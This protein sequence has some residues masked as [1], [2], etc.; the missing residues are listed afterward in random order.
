M[1]L[2][3]KYFFKTLDPD[4][5]P[6]AGYRR[7]L[8]PDPKT[9]TRNLVVGIGVQSELEHDD[10]VVDDGA[11][12]G[13]QAGPAHLKVAQPGQRALLLV[14]F[15]QHVQTRTNVV[16]A[17]RVGFPRQREK[18]I[19]IQQNFHSLRSGILGQL[20]LEILERIYCKHFF[21]C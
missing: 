6:E 13:E 17:L 8:H 4:S 7:L 16:V 5:K 20:H 1:F 2:Q 19:Y 3:F 15:H 14:A 12:D 10:E 11:E 21:I 18:L 9:K